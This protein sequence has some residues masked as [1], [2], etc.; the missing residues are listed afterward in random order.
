MA[1]IKDFAWGTA[2]AAYQIEGAY[3]EDGKG[4]N[5]WDVYTHQPNLIDDGYPGD[6]ACDHYHR[7]RE[8]VKLMKGL[9]HRA[10]RFSISWARV[11][12]EGTGE[13]N[14]KGVQF[15]SDLI[16]CLL[17]NGI[18]PHIT[19]FHWDLPYAL[20]K[21]GGWLNDDCVQWF[22]DYAEKMV[23]LFSD[24]V[25]YFITFNEPQ[26]FISGGYGTGTKAPGLKVCYKD[27]LQMAHNMLKCH[28][29]AVKAMR[30]AAKR[31]IK[32]GYAPTCSTFFPKS[33]SPE[34][35]EA[36]RKRY[37]ACSKLPSLWNV[38]WFSD[39]VMLGRYPEDGLQMYKDYLPE[40]TEE[41]MEL[42]H[43]PLDFYAQNIYTSQEVCADEN[44]EAVRVQRPI[45]HPL[46]ANKWAVSP[47]A[48]YWGPKFLYERYGLPISI[49]ENGMA[50]AAMP[51]P[52]GCVH[53][54]CRIEFLRRYLT[55][56]EK[57]TDDGIPI[58]GY[59]MW[60]L[61]DNYEW[62]L[63]YTTRHGLVYVDYETQKR[64]PKDS[65]YWYKEWIETH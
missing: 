63:G 17:E 52:D 47:E 30:A 38:S 11:L 40:I 54:P 41:D 23:A 44:G 59:F 56:L 13:L 7:F 45:G 62:T 65:A 25:E 43:Q 64:I 2:T 10:Y 39:P 57:A 48:L 33:N 29:A 60:T 42:I 16:D 1:F 27:L 28:G 46:T 26:C 61:M 53:D 34:D 55:S 18:Q 12:P 21:K 32:I 24:R 31:P 35:I 3:N 6:V 58:I 14:P 36:A 51:T 37:F 9:G 5:I 15:Y 50:D 4:L 49:T 22:A 8:D 19:L 20:H